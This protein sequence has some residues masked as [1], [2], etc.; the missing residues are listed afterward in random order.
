MESNQSPVNMRKAKRAAAAQKLINLR[1]ANNTA[2][3]EDSPLE[4]QLVD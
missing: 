3:I 4:K 2:P 1:Q